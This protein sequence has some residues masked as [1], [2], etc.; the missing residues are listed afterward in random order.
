MDKKI[1]KV[2]L[3]NKQL[4]VEEEFNDGFDPENFEETKTVE[5]QDLN[6]VRETHEIVSITITKK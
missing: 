6:D 4:K 5:P 2:D 1:Y 3:E